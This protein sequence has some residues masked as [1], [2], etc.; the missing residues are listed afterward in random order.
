[1]YDSLDTWRH[2]KSHWLEIWEA[3][4]TMWTVP[5]EIV[6]WGVI[7]LLVWIEKQTKNL[8]FMSHIFCN[9]R[10]I[11]SILSNIYFILMCHRLGILSRDYFCFSVCIQP[12]K[13]SLVRQKFVCICFL[14]LIDCLV[15]SVSYSI[16]PFHN[17]WHMKWHACW[18]IYHQDTIK[19]LH[20]PQNLPSE[21][22]YKFPWLIGKKLFSKRLRVCNYIW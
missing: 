1:M 12:S 11:I 2:C 5:I 21:I 8:I 22:L 16:L 18:L 15:C 10:I 13:R 20:L 14:F 9:K 6:V 7:A 17:W 19:G 4:S 3:M